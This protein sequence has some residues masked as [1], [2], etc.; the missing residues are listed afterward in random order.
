MAKPFRKLGGKTRRQNRKAALEAA[1]R[2]HG[3]NTRND[4]AK[5]I[6]NQ[7]KAKIKD[8]KEYRR[9][10]RLVEKGLEFSRQVEEETIREQ[11]ELK[12]AMETLNQAFADYEAGK[13]S[14]GIFKHRTGMSYPEVLHLLLRQEEANEAC[15]IMWQVEK[16]LLTRAEARTVIGGART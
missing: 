1:Q 4:R 15:E 14:R 2:Q 10:V 12:W 7:L 5:R 6:R 3:M 13:I 11:Q 9:V 16:G 8:P